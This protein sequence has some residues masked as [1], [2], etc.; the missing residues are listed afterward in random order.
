M[1]VISLHDVLHDMWRLQ[2]VVPLLSRAYDLAEPTP[3]LAL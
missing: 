1:A 3:L 2:G